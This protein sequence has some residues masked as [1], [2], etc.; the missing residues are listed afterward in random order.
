MNLNLGAEVFF[1]P[2]DTRLFSME[3]LK[4][5]RIETMLCG[6]FAVSFGSV[7]TPNQR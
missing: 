4:P 5:W 6:M 7:L 1:L 3:Q 2:A